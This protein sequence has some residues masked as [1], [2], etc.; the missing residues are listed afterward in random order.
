MR[1]PVKI[2]SVLVTAV[3]ECPDCGHLT[4]M[5]NFVNTVF[6]VDGVT[7]EYRYRLRCLKCLG[8]Y[9]VT[10]R[11]RTEVVESNYEKSNQG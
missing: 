4:E 2:D 5:T 3:S 1:S 8:S 7:P 11:A 6:F 9:Q 10:V